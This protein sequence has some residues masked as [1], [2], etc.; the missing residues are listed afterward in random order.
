MRVESSKA[1]KAHTL[2]YSITNG[3]KNSHFHWLLCAVNSK[4]NHTMDVSYEIIMLPY[5][6]DSRDIWLWKKHSWEHTT[7]MLLSKQWILNDKIDLKFSKINKKKYIIEM[8]QG[9]FEF[10]SKLKID[11]HTKWLLVLTSKFNA[12]YSSKWRNGTLNVITI[13]NFVVTSSV[14]ISVRPVHCYSA[15]TLRYLAC[16]PVP[17]LI[18]LE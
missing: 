11:V 8:L 10:C 15:G 3:L 1:S 9:L 16:E 12:I 4:S 13:R 7:S 5:P 6:K 17:G 14:H 18:L 2:T